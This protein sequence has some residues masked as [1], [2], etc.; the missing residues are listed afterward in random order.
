MIERIREYAYILKDVIWSTLA[1]LLSN[2]VL[3]LALYPILRNIFGAEMYGEVLYLVGIVNIIATA[4]GS[5]ASMARLK[6]SSEC[7]DN[8]KPYNLFL[9]AAFIAIFPVL[10]VILYAGGSEI[11]F[12]FLLLYWIL[13]CLTTYRFYANVE[14][15]LTTDYKGYFIYN[16]VTSIGYLVGAAVVYIT[17]FWMFAFLIGEI[18]GV[19]LAVFQ[20]RTQRRQQKNQAFNMKKVVRSIFFLCGS[21]LL[22]N[23][24]FNADRLLLK[25]FVNGTA[26][27]IYYVSSLI[28]KTIALITE[29]INNVLLGHLAKKEGMIQSTL[30]LKISGIIGVCAA[31]VVG[32]CVLGSHIFVYLFYPQ[33]YDVAKGFFILANSAQVLYFATGIVTTILLRYVN[34]RF[35]L[36]IN[37]FYACAFLGITLPATIWGGISAFAVSLCFVNAARFLFAV[38]VGYI[39][40][41][42]HNK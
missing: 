32:I 19:S 13:T 39:Q 30:F 22:V 6:A 11:S 33:E 37:L 27:T 2:V 40:I 17:H 8:Y 12:G 20:S 16:L 3:Q 25:V 31:A 7:P 23:L 41:K 35:Q 15:R 38:I 4:T 21:L 36:Y 29:P 26:V 28:G 5:S 1:A 42:R 18:F 9:F 34:E 24:V 14:Y 10:I